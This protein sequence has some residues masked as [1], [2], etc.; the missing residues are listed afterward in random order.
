MRRGARRANPALGA[1]RVYRK[2]SGQSLGSRWEVKAADPGAPGDAAV[3]AATLSQEIA[4]APQRLALAASGNVLKIDVELPAGYHL[5]DAAPQRVQVSVARGATVLSLAGEQTF[6]SG[7]KDVK[8]PLTVPLRA[9]GA[10]AAELRAQLTAYYCREDNTGTCRVKT[11]VWK[12][13]VRVS[14]DAN[15]PREIILRAKISE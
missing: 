7:G 5:N 12:V 13:P 8:L 3:A 15:A 6:K 14:A 10:G 2:F 1:R 4:V 9:P 11:L